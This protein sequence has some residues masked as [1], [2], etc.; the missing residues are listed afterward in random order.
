MNFDTDHNFIGNEIY[1]QEDM[2]VYG[3]YVE[4]LSLRQVCIQVII[5]MGKVVF[6]F[7]SQLV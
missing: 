7:L 5:W 1:V 6:V 2:K 3:N 4:L